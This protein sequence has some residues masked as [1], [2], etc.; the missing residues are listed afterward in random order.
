[1]LGVRPPQN[2]S[3]GAQGPESKVGIVSGTPEKTNTHG[4]YLFVEVEIFLKKSISHDI[5]EFFH[6]YIL[7]VIQANEAADHIGGL[8]LSIL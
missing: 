4:L 6:K 3:S 5:L 1:M 2:G 7:R 8:R